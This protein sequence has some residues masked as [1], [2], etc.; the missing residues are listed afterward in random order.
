[1][2]RFTGNAAEV[3]ASLI[4][5]A[6]GSIDMVVIAETAADLDQPTLFPDVTPAPFCF[7]TPETDHKKN[8]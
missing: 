5:Q 1:M 4:V 2:T 8:D 3:L 7:W 6:G